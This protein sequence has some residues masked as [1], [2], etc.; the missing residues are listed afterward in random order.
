[1]NKAKLIFASVLILLSVNPTIR[2]ATITLDSPG[3]PVSAAPDMQQ[4]LSNAKVS[5]NPPWITK[6]IS[7]S[8][9][10]PIVCSMEETLVLRDSGQAVTS[11]AVWIK[12]DTREPMITIRVPI[13]VYLAAGLAIRID[14]GK[15]W[16]LP[17]ETCDTQGCAAQMQ[18]SSELLAALKGGK[19]F[20]ITFQN[21]VKKDL[22]VRLVLNGFTEAFQKIQ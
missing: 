15:P 1:M 5:T 2:A 10:S 13:G 21:A 3:A 12:P 7:Q 20:S 6:C 9:T 19:Q 11:V 17:I 8:R 4:N 14:N 16:S 22:V 18:I